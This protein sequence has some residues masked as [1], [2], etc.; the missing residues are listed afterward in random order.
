MKKFDN[1]L[2]AIQK[3]LSEMADL[4][5][6]MVYLTAA[7][8]KDRTRDVLSEIYAC[9]GRLNTMQTHIDHEAIRMLTVYGPV[10]KDLRFVLVSTHMTSQLER[11]GDQVVNVIQSLQMIRSAP[12]THPLLPNLEKMADLV[13]EMVDDALDAYFSQNS[14]KAVVTRQRD[15]VVDAMNDQV[16]KELLTDE[17]LRQV[18]SGATDIADAVAQILI[19]RCLERIADQATNVCKEVIYMVKGDDVRHK[20]PKPWGTPEGAS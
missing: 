15:D 6:S 3:Q 4:A 5:R 9:E 14:E 11:M 13:C 2:A 1:E 8:V 18:L 16:M 12:A 7:A 17:V 10:A 20:R 19:A